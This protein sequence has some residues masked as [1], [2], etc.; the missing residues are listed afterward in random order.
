MYPPEWIIT[1]SIAHIKIT[2]SYQLTPGWFT[3]PTQLGFTFT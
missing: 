2:L 1:A 3:I